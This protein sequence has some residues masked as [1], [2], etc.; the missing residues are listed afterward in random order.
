MLANQ[1]V[2]LQLIGAEA[3]QIKCLSG[4]NDGMVRGD[5]LVIPDTRDKLPVQ[6]IQ[7]RG[8]SGDRILPLPPERRVFPAASKLEG[9]RSLSGVG[10]RFMGF[11]K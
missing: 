6:L 9:N 8:H 11:V 7:Y 10:G 2:D 5:F 1:M 4:G 3:R